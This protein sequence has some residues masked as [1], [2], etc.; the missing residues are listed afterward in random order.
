MAEANGGG[1]V[2][3]CRWGPQPC[4]FQVDLFRAGVWRRDAMIFIYLKTI[5]VAIGLLK[6]AGPLH[7]WCIAVTGQPCPSLLCNHC[8]NLIV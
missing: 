2:Q 3:A 1:S 8:S 4:L 6:T 7:V 5:I